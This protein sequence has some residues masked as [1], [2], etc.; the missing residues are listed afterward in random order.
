MRGWII[1]WFFIVGGF[2]IAI[3]AE[4]THY[5]RISFE[6]VFDTLTANQSI[7]MFDTSNFSISNLPKRVLT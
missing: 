5:S 3:A 7:P 2:M 4:R 1:M 6:S